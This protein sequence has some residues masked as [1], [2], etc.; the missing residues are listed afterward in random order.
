MMEKRVKLQIEEN[1]SGQR[2]DKLLATLYGDRYSRS[3]FH[4]VFE[5]GRIW[6]NGEVAKKQYRT[7][8][9]DVIE[10]AFITL[11]EP[12]LT[13]HK[14]PLHIL[15]EDETL[16]ILNK[17]AGLCVHPAPG[18]WNDTLVHGLLYHCQQIAEE[19]RQEDSRPG[20]VHR[21]DKDTSGVI[22]IAKTAWMHAQLVKA[23]SERQVHKEYLA[24]TWGN[25]GKGIINAPIA[26]SLQD[27]KKMCVCEKRGKS[28]LTE[29]IALY[30]DSR[31]S[32][33]RLYPQTGR[34]HQIRVHLAHR[35]A[36][37]LGDALYGNKQINERWG[38]KRQL[39]H[40]HKLRFIHPLTK[41]SLLFEAPIPEDIRFWEEK[42]RICAK[43][44]LS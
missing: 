23:F 2:L 7:E 31:A 29:V 16:L 36:P 9:A 35:G 44:F 1:Q 20:I 14:M 4:K 25:P 12:D 27:R 43:S 30:A 26:R 18:N 40:A 10:V 21:L 37:I 42:L 11:P 41:E 15:Y 5:E 22:A 34:T 28:A 19:F 13:P 32:V 3:Y 17:P 33:V 39:L 38:V 6:V 24:I 8:I